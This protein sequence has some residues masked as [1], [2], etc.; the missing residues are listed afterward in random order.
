MKAAVFT[1][2][3]DADVIK[4]QTIEKP[5]P[6]PDEVLVKVYATTVTTGDWRVLGP[7]APSGFGC[8]MRCFFGCCS[9][10]MNVLGQ[11]FAGVVEE[12]GAN[13]TEF[14]VGDEVFGTNDIN[15]GAHAEYITIAENFALIKKPS[16]MGMCESATIPFGAVTSLY[17]IRDVA[18]IKDGGNVVINGA[19]GCLGTFAIQIVKILSPTCKVTAICSRSNEALV[20]MLGADEFID[21]NENDFTQ[22]NEKY[23]V[24]YDTIGRIN[25]SAATN[26]MSENAIFMTAA[27]SLGALGT[28]LLNA[29]YCCGSKKFTTGTPVIGTGTK[30]DLA[31]LKKWIEE[32]KLKTV[33]DSKYSLDN[34]SEA[35]RLVASGHKKGNAVVLVKEEKSETGMMIVRAP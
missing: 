2:Y 25:Y 33:I 26:V 28:M 3:G 9:P 35:F 1:E 6:R 10:R 24:I 20:R 34:I 15:W 22:G 29:C 13:V 19:S 8:L 23:D 14:K 12:I 7:N 16:N 32:G 5:V 27:P 30:A 18:E 21:Y 4:V 11:E 17:F 31:C